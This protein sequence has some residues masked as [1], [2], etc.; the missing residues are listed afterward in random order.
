MNY[1][2]TVHTHACEGCAGPLERFRKPAARFC[3]VCGPKRR[4]AQILAYQAR[5]K[6]TPTHPRE[7]R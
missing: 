1:R 2:N 4:Y 5:K 3:I 7:E 6:A